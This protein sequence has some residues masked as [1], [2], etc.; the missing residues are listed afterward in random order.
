MFKK[1][2]NT[3]Y[4]EKRINEPGEPIRRIVWA[5]DQDRYFAKMFPFYCLYLVQILGQVLFTHV[6]R[7][8]AVLQDNLLKAQWE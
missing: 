4:L 8:S 2:P 5:G 7:R 3:D 6:I 1:G